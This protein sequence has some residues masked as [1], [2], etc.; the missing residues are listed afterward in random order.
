MKELTHYIFSFGAS[1]YALSA[2]GQLSWYSIAVALWLSLSVNYVIDALGHSM[3]GIPS[4]TRLTH[5]IFTAPVWG[6]LISSTSVFVFSQATYSS[7]PIAVLGFWTAAGALIAMGHLLL[8]SMT[9]AGVY[10]W[11][12]RIALSHFKYDNPVLNAGFILIGLGL[13]SLALVQSA[14]MS[15]MLQ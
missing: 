7:P 8:D 3:V 1:F 14:P 10:Y 5:S 15:Q 12:N 11:R 2:L 9:Q 6:G 4:R 13:L